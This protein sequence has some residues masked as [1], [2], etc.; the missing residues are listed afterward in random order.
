MHE[1]VIELVF[2]T[3]AHEVA[4][5]AYYQEHLL[6]GEKELYGDAGLDSATSYDEWLDKIERD[7]DCEIHSLAHF[8]IR[9]SDNKLIGTINIRYPYEGYVRRYGH[10]GY[11]VRPSERGKGYAT[12]ML[13][14]A[15]ARCKVL[16]LDKVLLT[17]DRNNI[18]S[19][20]T[21]LRCGGVFECEAPEQDGERLHRYWIALYAGSIAIV[22]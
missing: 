11:G 4:A 3:K 2:P 12:A 21:I 17:C 13:R 22:H 9:K 1:N 15:L 18:A 20:R 10:I 16:G 5:A 7:I 19:A 14:L 6:A 8:A